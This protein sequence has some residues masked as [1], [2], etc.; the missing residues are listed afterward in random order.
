MRLLLMLYVH[1]Y[2]DNL[3]SYQTAYMQLILLYACL[4]IQVFSIR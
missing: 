4:F 1:N 3:V 2:G